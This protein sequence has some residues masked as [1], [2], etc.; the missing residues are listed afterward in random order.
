MFGGSHFLRMTGCLEPEEVPPAQPDVARF[1]A[2]HG[3]DAETRAPS[4]AGEEITIRFLQ[5]LQ[6]SADAHAREFQDRLKQL[7]QRLGLELESDLRER[8]AY[9]KAREMG[10]LE[11]AIKVLR[12][13]LS[14]AREEMGTLEAKIQE[15]KSASQPP[16]K[17]CP[18]RPFRRRDASSLL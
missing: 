18:P 5:E 8:A 13:S 6:E 15:L 9:A 10:A 7:T 1:G 16:R 4:L 11:E 12:E 2:L 3:A 14:A 17:T